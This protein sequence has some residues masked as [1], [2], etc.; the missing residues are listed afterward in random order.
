MRLL[1][2]LE[3]LPTSL[4]LA[5]I[6]TLISP[7]LCGELIIEVTKNATCTRKTKNGDR[8]FM[9]YTGIL[10]SDGSQFDSSVGRGPFSFTLGGHEVI[11]GWDKGLLD[12]CLHEGRRLTIPAEMAYGDQGAGAAI[13]PKST[14]I[15]DTELLGIGKLGE[16]KEAT[17]SSASTGAGST[18]FPLILPEPGGKASEKGP[19]HDDDGSNNGE[20]RLL[21]PFALVVQAAL[22]ILA[23]MSLVFKR[24]RESPRRSLKVWSFDVSKQVVGS[25]LLHLANLLMSMLSSGKF[26]IAQKA[27]PTITEDGKKDFPNPCSF[28][29]LNVAI[30]T[31]IGIPILVILLRLL[32]AGF[33]RTPL[34]NP[35]ESLKSGNYGNPPKTTWWLKQSLLYFIG[36]VGMKLCV[37]FLFQILPWLGWVGDWALRWTEGKEWMQI[38][39]VMLIFPLV[40]N[41]MQYYI[42]DS[43]IKDSGSSQGYEQAPEE[44]G[45]EHEGLIGGNGGDSDDELDGAAVRNRSVSPKARTKEANP[46]VVP[47]EY[48]DVR[49]GAGSSLG[50]GSIDSDPKKK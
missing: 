48:E 41:A 19:K 34:A 29:V 47:A 17:T 9:Q 35:P 39:F 42:I 45:D 28:Y 32:H 43:F 24:W 6:A 49:D 31:T 3:A 18:S 25:A 33:S 11:K 10:Q 36:L 27:A 15:F 14:L 13:P 30:D 21:G 16:P 8:V 50:K 1:S 46:T 37:F 40:M 20:C 22:G 44:E 26:D 4:S 23:V 7:A 12:M 5:L 2:N 38:T